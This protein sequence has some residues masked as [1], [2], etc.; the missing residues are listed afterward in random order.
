MTGRTVLFFYG[1]SLEAFFPTTGAFRA[2][3][4]TRVAVAIQDFSP[5]FFLLF[6]HPQIFGFCFFRK[7]RIS[8]V[9]IFFGQILVLDHALR[10][11]NARGGSRGSGDPRVDRGFVQVGRDVRSPLGRTH[12]EARSD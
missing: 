1:R 9:H 3:V 4:D 7:N 12:H 5:I 6:L 2:F 11:A 10:C 8:L